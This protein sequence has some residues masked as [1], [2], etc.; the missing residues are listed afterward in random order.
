MR[1]TPIGH[2]LYITIM[3][4]WWAGP[5]WP[6]RLLASCPSSCL[7]GST[8]GRM[9]CWPQQPMVST[10]LAL[11]SIRHHFAGTVCKFLNAFELLLPL[12]HVLSHVLAY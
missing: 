8:Q 12:S 1:R 3:G 2:R 4:A 9:R 7:R 6:E 10:L 11:A 5:G